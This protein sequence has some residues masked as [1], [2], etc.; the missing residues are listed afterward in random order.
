MQDKIIQN[1]MQVMKNKKLLKSF[2]PN[3][4][5]NPFESRDGK[6]FQDDRDLYYFDEI[7][8]P[9]KETANINETDIK[10]FLYETQIFENI[11]VPHVDIRGLKNNFENL[12]FLASEVDGKVEDKSFTLIKLDYFC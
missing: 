5:F 12:M 8:I 9:S 2:W 6:F 1:S 7:N 10:N 4:L 3:L 11:P